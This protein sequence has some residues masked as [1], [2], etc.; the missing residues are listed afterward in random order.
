MGLLRTRFP[1]TFPGP[2]PRLVLIDP[3]KQHDLGLESNSAVTS[4]V[5][6]NWTLVHFPPRGSLLGQER[7]HQSR[8]GVD[9]SEAPFTPGFNVC[10][11][12]KDRKWTAASTGVNASQTCL[13][14]WSLKPLS[15]VDW[16]THGH[17]TFGVRTQKR[18]DASQTAMKDQLIDCVVAV[19]RKYVI[20]LRLFGKSHWTEFSAA[21]LMDKCYAI[22][23]ETKSMLFI[24]SLISSLITR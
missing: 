24:V 12:W 13:V 4:A 16:D 6:S 3:C 10:P 19:A 5:C 21:R 2:Y 8:S 9:E 11:G 14:I 7:T 18:L 17:I 1:G 22:R 15:E 20:V 23:T